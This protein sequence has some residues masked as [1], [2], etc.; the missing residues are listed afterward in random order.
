MAHNCVKLNFI[1]PHV[2]PADECTS[3]QW[4]DLDF[5]YGLKL[6]LNEYFKSIRNLK[7]Y[8]MSFQKFSIY[9]IYELYIVKSSVSTERKKML[10]HISISI[11]LMIL[12]RLACS[13]SSVQEI[14]LSPPISSLNITENKAAYRE[15]NSD[16]LGLTLSQTALALVKDYVLYASS[17]LP[18]E[19]F[20]KL[21]EILILCE[22]FTCPR[23]YQSGHDCFTNDF[24]EETIELVVAY[25]EKFMPS[26]SEYK[27]FGASVSKRIHPQFKFEADKKKGYAPVLTVAPFSDALNEAADADG[28]SSDDEFLLNDKY[29]TLP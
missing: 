16:K 27:H 4:I 20:W 24:E 18:P 29:F 22:G 19:F 1:D 11:L 17:I 7:T 28:E 2:A 25:V 15:Y 21:D 10:V 23:P 3:S 13:V 14:M 8:L 5:E 6:V 9:S 26:G 12:N